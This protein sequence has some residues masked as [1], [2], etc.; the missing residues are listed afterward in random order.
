[1]NK[2]KNDKYILNNRDETD[3][4]FRII[5]TVENIMLYDHYF[6]PEV[7]GAVVPLPAGVVPFTGGIVP[8]TAGVVPFRGVV[9]FAGIEAGK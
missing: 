5:I 2:K 4:C 8:F 6:P 7:G 1:M 3:S 9:P